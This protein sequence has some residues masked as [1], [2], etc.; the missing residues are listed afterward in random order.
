MGSELID[1]EVVGV[2]FGVYSADEVLGLSVAALSNGH[3]F[4]SLHQPVPGGL[5]DERMGPLD[6]HDRCVSCHQT[7]STCLGHLAHISL[8]LPVYQP[9]VFDLCFKL[10]KAKCW[11]C[12]RL[13][14]GR[15]RVK[16]ALTKLQLI[17]AGLLQQAQ[18][19]DDTDLL[20]GDE[21]KQLR[22]AAADRKRKDKAKAKKDSGRQR[23]TQTQRRQRQK[24]SSD[25]AQQQ[26]STTSTH[27]A[28]APLV[29]DQAEDEEEEEEEDDEEEEGEGVDG[30]LS[31]ATSSAG[32]AAMS[33][34][35]RLSAT[36]S[37]AYAR[38]V[39]LFG[40][41]P[42]L[43]SAAL[44]YRSGLISA[45]VRDLQQRRCLNCGGFSPRLRKDGHSKIFRLPLVRKE[46][47]SNDLHHLTFDTAPL[48]SAS[49]RL[50]GALATQQRSVEVDAKLLQSVQQRRER[51][52]AGGS[53]AQT[54]PSSAGSGKA[55]SEPAKRTHRSRR[56]AATTADDSG[57]SGV[58][59]SDSDADG[60]ESMGGSEDERG[61]VAGASDGVDRSL[62]ADDERGLQVELDMAAEAR[63]VPVLMFPSEVEAH[64]ER[65]WT[66]EGEVLGHVWGS[67]FNAPLLPQSRRSPLSHS[68]FFMRVLAVPPSRFRPPSLLN[69]VESDH[70]HNTYLKQIIEADARIRRMAMGRPQRSSPTSAAA[71][72]PR[73]AVGLSEAGALDWTALIDSWLALQ[74]AVN[75]LLDSSK[76]SSPNAPQDGV[77]QLFEKK[78][79]L[80]RRN[81]MGKRVN[82]AA[83][84]VIS[85]D[86]FL[87]TNEIGVP[88]MFATQLTFPEPVTS[89]NVHVL[90]QAVLNGPEVHPGAVAIEDERGQVVSLAHKSPAQRSALSRTL[91][92]TTTAVKG[93]ATA[94]ATPLSCKRVLRHIRSGDVMLV[95]RQPT[96][97]KPSM[98][99]HRVR[100][101]RGR[102]KMW[103]TIRM[104]Y[105]NCNSYNADF[106]GDEMNLHLPQNQ[107][108][109]A[110]AYT[111]SNTDHQYLVPTDGSPLRGLIQDNVLTGV[112]LTQLDTFLTRAQFQQLL[113]CCVEVLDTLP[114]STP[115]PAIAKPVELF[116]GKQ[117][118]GSLLQLLTHG[119]PALNL[120]SKAKVPVANWK[121]HTEEATIIIRG[122]A[123]CTGVLDKSQFG[124]AGYGLVHAV[125]E[126]Y[127]ANTAGQLLSTL[128]RLFTLYLQ[129]QA[130]TCG[131]DDMLIVERS[132]AERH[133]LIQSSAAMG[134][135]AALD[136]ASLSYDPAQPTAVH[137][138][139]QQSLR[140]PANVARLDSVMKGA[141]NPFTS[142]IISACL[143][144]GQLKPFPLNG[145]SLMTLSGA[146]G[147]AVNF[148]QISCLLGQQELEGKRV[149]HMA[150]GKTLPSFRRY[151][152]APRAGGYV[153]DRFLT[154]IRPQEYYFHC[155]A[156]REGL[157][158]TA[159]K[160]SRS[161]YLQRCLIKHLESLTVHY[162]YTVR[163]SDSSI[164]QFHYGEDSVDISRTSY[165][166]R[167]DFLTH[168][169]RALLHKLNPPAAIQALDTKA[170]EDYERAALDKQR[171]GDSEEGGEGGVV[172]ADPVLS[173]FSPGAHLGAV[174]EAFRDA[175]ATFVLRDEERLFT[176]AGSPSTSTSPSTPRVTVDKF[177][178]LMHLNYLYS[179]VHPGESVG[180]L[181]AQSVGEPSTQMTLNTFHLAGH[182]GANVTLGIPRLREIIMT[183]S[184]RIKTPIMEVPM[185]DPK[186]TRA[187]AE[188]VAATLNRLTLPS[189][190]SSATVRE[191]VEATER[192]A[193]YRLYSVRLAFAEPTSAAVAASRLSFRDFELAFAHQFC[194]RL[195][196]AVKK[197]VKLLSA[198]HAVS[199]VIVRASKRTQSRDGVV[200][201]GAEGS[202][203]PE[204]G[205]G[206]GEGRRRRGRGRAV[207]EDAVTAKERRRHREEVSYEEPD[208][209]DLDIIHREERQ[210]EERE[211]ADDEEEGEE[212]E[213][214]GAEEERQR[215]RLE[216]KYDEEEQQGEGEAGAGDGS[217][218]GKDD[219]EGSDASSSSAS[220]SLWLSAVLN[221]CSYLRTIRFDPKQC[222]A[223]VVVAVSLS[224]PKLLLM[225]MV[226]QLVEGVLLRATPGISRAFVVEKST[227]GGPKALSVCTDGLN[228][229]EVALYAD[230]LDVDRLYSNDIAA[231]LRHYGVEA[232]RTAITK[233]VQA[234]FAPYGI[235][236]DYRH[237]SLIADYMTRNGE[238]R[239]LNRGGIDSNTSAFQKISFE[240]S[241]HFLREA[242][243]LGD[244]DYLHSPSAN[245]VVGKPVTC[246]TGAFT[247]MQPIPPLTTRHGNTAST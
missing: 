215:K 225:S 159:V 157:I 153:T 146:K 79:G 61:G 108:A 11:L 19:L 3:T 26:R 83:R 179:L 133:A 124:D 109:R 111:I 206:G 152:P 200:D 138:A 233:E 184:A 76:S 93:G 143:P 74:E 216:H 162:D 196:A 114:L 69:G 94:A 211:R 242:A 122:N 5:Y 135:S 164:V 105:A 13:K 78:E 104:H 238:Y 148:S 71:A 214:D 21:A 25:Q 54:K 106:D 144:S 29:D 8:T 103:Q 96:L 125:Y 87:S 175:M 129:S 197:E 67:V 131:I 95:N 210:R 201:G 63:R 168:N 51:D 17:E 127:G 56:G 219:V 38:H 239:P 90:R 39:R 55:A 240:T 165:L 97:H 158:D 230:V 229:R 139:L 64:L 136:F 66:E 80:F 107:L 7:Q 232:A 185:R 194:V 45:F 116:T 191:S 167:F 246:G 75:G 1:H 178:A 137:S 81:M 243:L 173:I 85:P 212:E 98:M 58:D 236:V 154:G 14:L 169:W 190:L 237:L 86:P 163:D 24:Q 117:L 43:T 227:G 20:K 6:P 65:L 119:R 207:E 33:R 189:F 174:S 160:T 73:P 92:T 120:V 48:T 70:P 4:D 181:A 198:Q 47:Q 193:S 123:L 220:S 241:M 171:K 209:D 49:Q 35:H 132:E 149:P 186:A 15:L 27:T 36:A 100:V 2:S 228:F 44:E 77:R 128:G 166:E 31:S 188:E 203:E 112:L 121:Q 156:G 142:N 57:D 99:T 10:L 32:V 208:D 62:L 28:A 23:Q 204:E 59:S 52:R 161:G 172:V 222:W 88:E 247:L 82:Y 134:L 46:Q 223:E 91:L 37:A 245:I 235:S 40:Q 12:H 217:E 147:S 101:L 205:G 84:S 234:V 30:S 68:L 151:D 130:F 53:R 187:Q 192:G 221:R 126:L 183:A 102:D 115:R 177:R 42:P 41:P 150:T 140:D 16:R 118:I 199:P 72:D 141:L 18:L 155:M 213:D 231:I 182:G 180:I 22:K 195:N 202:E 226:E 113:F 9:V 60:A 244:V 176:A 89:F 50:P 34:L 224:L 110:E 170:V 145:M 218:E